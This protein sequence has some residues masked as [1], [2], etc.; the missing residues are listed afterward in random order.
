MPSSL[1][2]NDKT[3]PR[4]KHDVAMS[5]AMTRLPDSPDLR[6]QKNLNHQH[7]HQHHQA[8]NIAAQQQQQQRKATMPELFLDGSGTTQSNKAGEDHSTI[9]N[10]ANRASATTAATKPTTYQQQQNPQQQQQHQKQ[11][12]SI[13]RLRSVAKYNAFHPQAMACSN[14]AL[15]AA[16][17]SSYEATMNGDDSGDTSNAITSLGAIAGPRGVALFRLSKPHIPLL[18]FSHTTSSSNN[19]NNTDS[20]SL[21]ATATTRRKNKFASKTANNSITSLA[22]QPTISYHHTSYESSVG[23]RQSGVIKSNNHQTLYLAAARGSGVL[24]W[25]ASGHS[26]NPLL[27]RLLINDLVNNDSTNNSSRYYGGIGNSGSKNSLSETFITSMSWMPSSSISNFNNPLLA[28]TTSS[29]LSMW[30]LRCPHTSGLFQPSLRFANNINHQ[31]TSMS[32][33]IK[34]APIVQV[35]CSSC[36]VECATIDASGVVRIYD[37][38]KT[39]KGGPVTSFIAHEAGVGI[40]HMERKIT[41]T[42]STCNN[43]NGTITTSSAWVTWGLDSPMSSATVKVWGTPNSSN[44]VSTSLDPNP[45]TAI[46]DTSSSVEKDEYWY[47]GDDDDKSSSQQQELTAAAVSITKLNSI[48]YSSTSNNSTRSN[49]S[50]NDDKHNDNGSNNTV[51]SS[52]MN[53]QLI[54]QYKRSNICCARICPSPI[55]NSLVVVGYL[56]D[57]DKD[58]DDENNNSVFAFTSSPNNNSKNEIATP[59]YDNDDTATNISSHGGWWVDVLKLTTTIPSSSSLL[60]Q[61]PPNR[62]RRSSF[63]FDQVV[64]FAGGAA[65]ADVDK[66]SLV[67]VLGNADVGKLQAAELAFSSLSSSLLSS[68]I[69][70]DNNNK[71]RSTTKA[72][73]GTIIVDD[74]EK[75]GNT[76]TDKIELL[77]CCLS[78]TG[79]ITTT[80]IPEALPAVSNITFDVASSNKKQNDQ[81]YDPSSSPQRRNKIIRTAFGST[82]LNNRAKVFPDTYEGDSLVDVASI[83]G[84]LAGT[85]TATATATA[86]ANCV[87]EYGKNIEQSRLSSPVKHSSAALDGRTTTPASSAIGDSLRSN[88]RRRIEGEGFMPFDMDVSISVAYNALSA[89]NLGLT[90]MA[91]L[92][93]MINTTGEDG[94][95]TTARNLTSV[96][97]NIDTERIPCPRLCGTLILILVIATVTVTVTVTVVVVRLLFRLFTFYSAYHMRFFS[98]ILSND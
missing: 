75:K 83:W 29:S 26:T 76:A 90:E 3:P 43:D 80:S 63:G 4:Q 56:D 72:D 40:H 36:S 18:I 54:A 23:R 13:R 32:V 24:I 39:E 70:Y 6:Y 69:M 52:S 33:G 77:L 15:S 27:G 84:S 7:Q 89:A 9:L 8:I 73:D 87:D 78:D 1:Y 93:A 66:R 12:Q 67:S 86:A 95:E 82:S 35:A 59:S 44:E 20:S 49:D 10:R 74:K 47:M 19:N 5:P 61:A 37:L 58:N 42:S 98:S 57:N 31:L 94:V 41:T 92:S 28:T 85:A 38:R 64:S 46:L 97:E 88:E 22:F 25:D 21:G 91:S 48:S 51:S 71:K 50:N 14:D 96:M 55:T 17:S 30:D 62:K 45:I 65:N 2:A 53:Y 79:I 60:L 34:R 81:H 11:Q 68:K 16:S